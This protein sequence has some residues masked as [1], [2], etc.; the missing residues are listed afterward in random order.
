MFYKIIAIRKTIEY[1]TLDEAK[2][3]LVQRD[4][5]DWGIIRK[6]LKSGERKEF[7]NLKKYLESGNAGGKRTKNV[8]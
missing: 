8:N 7:L 4:L 2:Q 3:H 6:V 5:I 1:M